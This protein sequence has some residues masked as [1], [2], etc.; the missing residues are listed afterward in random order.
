MCYVQNL[1]EG[2]KGFV[3]GSVAGKP[4]NSWTSLVVQWLRLRNSTAGDAGLIPGEGTKIPRAVRHGQKD[5]IRK[6]A[7]KNHQTLYDYL[8]C[9]QGLMGFCLLW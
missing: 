8:L 5:K 2:R 7:K 4:L 9:A 1:K 3:Q 6:E